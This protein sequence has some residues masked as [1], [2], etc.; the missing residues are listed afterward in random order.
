LANGVDSPHEQHP[1]NDPSLVADREEGL[2]TLT[3]QKA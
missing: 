2:T 1:R 3:P